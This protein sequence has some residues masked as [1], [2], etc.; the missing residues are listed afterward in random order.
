MHP[1]IA[2]QLDHRHAEL[3]AAVAHQRLINEFRQTRTDLGGYH[4]N[5]RPS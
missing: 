4:A 2:Y 1:D 5:R 3:I